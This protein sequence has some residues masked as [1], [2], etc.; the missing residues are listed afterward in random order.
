MNLS[1]TE[2]ALVFAG[3]VLVIGAIVV[4]WRRGVFAPKANT[5]NADTTNPAPGEAAK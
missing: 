3:C 2:M 4:L 1:S 5:N